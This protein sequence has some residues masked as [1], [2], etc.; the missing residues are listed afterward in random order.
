MYD[1]SHTCQ[2]S[3]TYFHFTN[4]FSNFF[5]FAKNFCILVY[6]DF[7]RDTFQNFLK[8]SFHKLFPFFYKK[9]FSSRV[10]SPILLMT[11]FGLGIIFKFFFI[12]QNFFIS[13][14]CEK[15]DLYLYHERF[16]THYKYLTF[17]MC[18]I[19]NI[20]SSTDSHPDFFESK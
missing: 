10:F 9:N 20:I 18:V 15:A 12:L 11:L 8:F 5:I 16:A 17:V 4:F 1:E 19:R 3:D 13:V 2:R 14:Q 7:A 6:S